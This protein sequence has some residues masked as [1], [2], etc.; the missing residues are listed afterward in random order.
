M[1]GPLGLGDSICKDWGDRG[2]DGM[3][4]AEQRVGSGDEAQKVGGY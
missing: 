1:S 3:G 2:G 4:K